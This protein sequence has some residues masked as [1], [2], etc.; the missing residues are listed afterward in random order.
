MESLTTDWHSSLPKLALLAM[1]TV[2]GLRLT[3]Y[4]IWRKNREGWVEDPRYTE[5]T[6]AVSRNEV[7]PV[8][9]QLV[10]YL[11]VFIMQGCFIW[12]V[13]F[14]TVIALLSPPEQAAPL[15]ENVFLPACIALWAIGKQSYTRFASRCCIATQRVHL[16]GTDHAWQVLY[17][18][19][20]RTFSC[21]VTLPTK[22][23][24]GRR[25]T[26]VSSNTRGIQ[27]T[28]EIS[29]VSRLYRPRKPPAPEWLPFLVAGGLV[30][31]LSD[32]RL[33]ELVA[34]IAVRWVPGPHV[35]DAAIRERCSHARQDPAGKA[36]V[37]RL[38][39]QHLC[40]FPVS[41]PSKGK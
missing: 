15:Q 9:F 1:V 36:K 26:T 17:L 22:N 37:P 19:L 12:M 35:C 32:V 7:H 8:V 33:A 27:T 3:L 2:W 20:D 11:Q 4:L 10:S 5:R 6:L 40:L 30:L 31:V 38:H 25:A 34:R 16:S 21:S 41:A 24:A 14:C 28:S 23:F 18:R 13:G 39:R 29:S